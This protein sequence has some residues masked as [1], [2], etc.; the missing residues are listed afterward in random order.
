VAVEDGIVT[1]ASLA[2][3]GLAPVPWRSAEAEAA[4]VGQPAGTAAFEAAA[5]TLL[6]DAKGHGHNDFKIVLARRTLI[7]SLRDLTTD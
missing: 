7:A 1:S 6:R 4:L 5:D 3:G 2:F